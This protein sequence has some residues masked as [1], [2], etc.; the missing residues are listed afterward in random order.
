MTD[1][2]PLAKKATLSRGMLFV[3]VLSAIVFVLAGWLVTSTHVTTAAVSPD[4]SRR[5]EIVDRSFRFI[6]RNFQVRIIDDKGSR[7]VF[8]SPDEPVSGV[9]Q[10]QLLWSKDGKRLLLVGKFWTREDAELAGGKSLYLLCDVASGQV[11]CNSD[12]NGNPG[13]G[14]DDLQGFDLSRLGQ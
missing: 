10:E 11:R 9:G 2:A 4:K 5:A 1:H 14:R 3:V 13:F 7:T 8:R 6:D 12:Q